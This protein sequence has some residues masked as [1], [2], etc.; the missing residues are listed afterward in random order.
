MNNIKI[1]KRTPLFEYNQIGK[2]EV[3]ELYS[4]VVTYEYYYDSIFKYEGT[5]EIKTSELLTDDKL[6]DKILLA[7]NEI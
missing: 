3:V 1:I 5:I 6:K 4:I 7:L 2:H